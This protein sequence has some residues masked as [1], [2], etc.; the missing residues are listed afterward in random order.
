MTRA[1]RTII[2]T[3]F[4]ALALLSA[5]SRLSADQDATAATAAAGTY[6]VK[7]AGCAKGEGKASSTGDTISITAT[8]KDE[9]GN[10]GSLSAPNLKVEKNHFKGTGTLFGHKVTLHGRLDAA[11]PDEPAI[12]AQRIVCT[13]TTA[14]GQHGRIAGYVPDGSGG[15]SGRKKH[16]TDDD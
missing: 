10:E 4:L 14:D 15:A 5:P 16:K 6:S 9:S 11:P 2:L 3:F 7:V 13:F 8:V 1:G 12:N